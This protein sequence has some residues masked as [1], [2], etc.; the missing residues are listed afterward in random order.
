[1][2]RCVSFDVDNSSLPIP[3]R[4]RPDLQVSAQSY[5][6]EP[7]WVVKEPLDLKYH[8]LNT[9]E[10]AV[11][12]WLQESLTLNQL[13]EK[14]DRKFAPDRVTTKE[15]QQFL[16]SLYQ[17]S[18]LTSDATGQGRHLLDLRKENKRKEALQ[19]IKNF[20]SIKWKGYDPERLLNRIYPYTG[21]FFSSRT[22]LINSFIILIAV[23]WALIH[24][25]NLCSDA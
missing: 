19:T 16:L 7:F 18:L 20:Y 3:L 8:H 25:R 21:W 15:L 23:V 10:F 5:R 17:K 14:F 6:G 22:V 24:Y 4:R 9:Q 11:F 13:R 12:N 2:A 1:M